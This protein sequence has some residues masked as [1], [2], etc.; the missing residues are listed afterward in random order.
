MLDA[1]AS[2]L[3]SKLCQHNLRKPSFYSQ[4]YHP[5]TSLT[6]LPWFLG[7]IKL[8]SVMLS[9][10]LAEF[11]GIKLEGMKSIEQKFW[12]TGA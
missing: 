11:L 4:N 10:M 7:S 8:V 1:F 3:C 6:I 2:L 5:K 9:I 12:H